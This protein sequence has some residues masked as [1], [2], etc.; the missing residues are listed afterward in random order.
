MCV[1]LVFVCVC[2]EWGECVVSGVS[3][4]VCSEECVRVCVVSVCVWSEC[5]CV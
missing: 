1:E 3:A 2:S 5:V 4:C